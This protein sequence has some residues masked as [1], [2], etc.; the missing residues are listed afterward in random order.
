MPAN[1]ST[2]TAEN[3]LFTKKLLAGN[4]IDPQ[5]FIVVHKP[6]MER[7]AYATFKKHWPGK[8][9]VVTSPQISFDNYPNNEISK[10]DLIN[11]MVGD[12]HRIKTYS[13]KGFQIFTSN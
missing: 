13:E 11:I 9:I 8:E 4:N 7:R 5:K 6:Y 1:K 2:N 10:D 3:V 12:L